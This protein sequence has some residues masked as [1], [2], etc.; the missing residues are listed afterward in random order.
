MKKEFSLSGPVAPSP[1]APGQERGLFRWSHYKAVCELTG[2][3]D[4]GLIVVAN[5]LG[6]FGYHAGILRGDIPNLLPYLAAGNIV[7]APICFW[8]RLPGQL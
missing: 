4:D 2:V 7:A 1:Q 5:A 3:L 6:G 8:R